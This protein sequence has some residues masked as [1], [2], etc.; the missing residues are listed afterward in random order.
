MRHQPRVKGR[1]DA[2]GSAVLHR[3]RAAVQHEADRFGCSKSF[4]V[5]TILGGH[6][7][8]NEQADYAESGVVR[9]IQKR[10]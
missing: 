5:A 2:L 1:R 8:I 6:F 9:R 7:G 4:V 3:I 10:A